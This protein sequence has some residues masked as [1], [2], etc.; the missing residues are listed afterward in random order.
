MIKLYLLDSERIWTTLSKTDGSYIFR[1]LP[2]GEYF[3]EITPLVD[4]A[5]AYTTSATV[6][7]SVSEG[8]G[9]AGI[10]FGLTLADKVWFVYL[11][12]T[13]R[14]VPATGLGVAEATR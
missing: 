9:V 14:S 4:T 7:I 6:N 10:D 12:A 1:H 13:I 8:S 3:I 11:P 5:F 2:D